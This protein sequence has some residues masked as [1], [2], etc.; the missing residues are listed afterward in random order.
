M[1]KLFMFLMVA[2]LF[3]GCTEAA[4][5]DPYG[6]WMGL[7]QGIIAPFSFI[8]SLF[9]DNIVVYSCNNTGG[10]YDFGFLLGIGAFAKGTSR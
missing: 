8:V 3:V 1:K 2:L 4:P 7:W 9:N 10:W 5:T 6:F